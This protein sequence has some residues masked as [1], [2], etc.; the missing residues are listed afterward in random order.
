MLNFDVLTPAA[1]LRIAAVTPFTSIDFPGKL[2][3]VVFLRGCPWRCSYCHNRW[4]RSRRSQEGDPNWAGIEA[5]LKK[6]KGLLDGIVFQAVNPVWI[7]RCRRLFVLLR[8]RGIW[9][10][11]TLQ[12]PIPGI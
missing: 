11:C 3:A 4:M 1:T 5:L 8:T 2:S 12:E 7:Q 6:R 9:S 10:G